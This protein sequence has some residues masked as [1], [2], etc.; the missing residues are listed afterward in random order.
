MTTISGEFDQPALLVVYLPEITSCL[1]GRDGCSVRVR[2][3]NMI[4]VD[5]APRSKW[6]HQHN[7]RS[8]KILNASVNLRI[9]PSN[10]K[11]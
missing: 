11:F 3:D 6:R 7:T 10:L 4:K 2:D 5:L 8:I 9:F 1:R